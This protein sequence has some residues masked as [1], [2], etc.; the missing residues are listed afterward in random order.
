MVVYGHTPVPEPEWIN[1]TICLDTGCVFGG[2]A[3]RAALPGARA[4]LGAGAR[5]VVLRPA[6]PFRPLGGG[7]A[8]AASPTCSSSTDVLGQRVVETRLT[9]PRDA[10]ARRTRPLR[11]R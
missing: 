1:N 9:R 4:R 6:K 7:A 10:C 3:H 5:E 2:T 8:P 11:S